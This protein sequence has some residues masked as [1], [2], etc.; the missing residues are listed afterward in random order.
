MIKIILEQFLPITLV[1]AWTF[2]ATP[3]KLNEIT[4]D[5]IVFEILADLPETMFV[6]SE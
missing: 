5:D 3:K 2:F 4:P 1:N 6:Q